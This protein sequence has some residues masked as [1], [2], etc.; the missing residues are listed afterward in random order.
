MDKRSRLISGAEHDEEPRLLSKTAG[1][2][3]AFCGIPV[4]ERR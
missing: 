4:V 2:G 3:D 1:T